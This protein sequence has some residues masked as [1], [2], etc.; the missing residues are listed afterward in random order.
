M[1]TSPP[2]ANRRGVWSWCLYDFA[3][4]PFATIVVSFIFPPYFQK[5]FFEAENVGKAVFSNGVTVTALC[6]ALASPFLGAMADSGDVTED[7]QPFFMC[8]A[9]VTCP[10]SAMAV[11]ADRQ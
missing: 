7:F 1:S 4:S 11:W 5:A 3:N 10:G 8:T 6:V 9:S 2:S